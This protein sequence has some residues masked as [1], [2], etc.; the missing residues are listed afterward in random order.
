MQPLN[1]G[2]VTPRRGFRAPWTSSA[3]KE[4]SG[5]NWPCLTRAPRMCMATTSTDMQCSGPSHPRDKDCD[6]KLKEDRLRGSLKASPSE[7]NFWCNFSQKNSS[8]GTQWPLGRRISVTSS[9]THK[10]FL[11]QGAC[12]RFHSAEARERSSSAHRKSQQSEV[13]VICSSPGV[14]FSDSVF[15]YT[16]LFN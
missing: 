2:S 15:P 9:A 13:H 5:I 1:A 12:G 3:P 16:P 14:Q 10:D 7:R 8:L 11:P 4:Q 6:K